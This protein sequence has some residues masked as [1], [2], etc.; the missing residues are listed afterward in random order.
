L[1]RTVA[2]SVVTEAF[3]MTTNA[4]RSRA[5]FFP[6]AGATAG[7]YPV[8]CELTLFGKG[9][10]ARSVRL[11]GG[12][13][14][15]PDGI[16]L[17]DAFPS[18]LTETSG[19]CGLQVLLETAQ[20][21]INLLNSRVVIEMVS[22]Q[23]S[24]AFSAAPFRPARASESS[25]ADAAVDREVLERT[26]V[27][28]AIQDKIFSSSVVAVHAGED[29]IR[30]DLRHVLRDAEVP[31]HMGTVAG[32]SVVEFPLDEALCKQGVQHDA[33]WGSAVIEKFW[34]RLGGELSG[35]SWYLLNRDPA[36]KRPLS[37]CAL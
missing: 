11:D 9:I 2:N 23:F 25:S 22:P 33:L 29:L 27:G 10:E 4:V 37:V 24:L 1:E 31:L 28:I 26:L 20:G 21:R 12:R 19:L 16:R 6:S 5:H 32:R 17:E 14:N 30:P 8:S 3:F 13:L 15:Q 35:V 7:H 18:L 36:T 34:G